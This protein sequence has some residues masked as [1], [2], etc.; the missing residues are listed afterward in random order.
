MSNILFVLFLFLGNS[1][2]NLKYRELPRFW[3]NTGFCPIGNVSQVLLSQDEEINI[4]LIGS[5]PNNGIKRVRIHWLLDLVEFSHYREHEIPVFDFEKLDK[6]MDSL[7]D[8]GLRVGFEL[9]GNPSGIFKNNSMWKMW[10]ELVFQIGKRYIDRYGPFKIR[11]WRFESWNEPDLTTYNKLNFTLPDYMK[12]LDSLKFG[13]SAAS[14]NPYS[15]T[16]VSLSGPAGL[17]KNIKHH[18]LCW[19]ILEECNKNVTK[20]PFDILTFHRKGESGGAS[21]IY[22]GGK[23]LLKEIFGKFP[24]LRALKISNNEADPV[25]GWSTPRDFQGDVRYAVKLVNTVLLHWKA[26]LMDDEFKNLESISHDNA[27]LSYHPF[28]FNQRTLFARFQMN[29]SQPIYSEFIV[30]PVYVA[31]GL[32]GNLG[33]YAGDLEEQKILDNKIKILKTVGALNTKLPNFLAWLIVA[34]KNTEQKYSFNVLVENPSNATFALLIE[35]VEPETTDPA[36]IWNRYDRPSYPERKFLELMRMYEGPKIAQHTLINENLM[37]ISCE[38]RSPAIALI[39]LCSDRI[40]PP[41]KVFDLRF[42]FVHNMEILLT[43]KEGFLRERC[44]KTYEIFQKDSNENWTMISRNLEIPFLYFFYYP[45]KGDVRGEYK[46]RGVDMFGRSGEF[47]DVIKV[48]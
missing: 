43:W 36:W 25:S 20:C 3:T 6:L 47:S 18:L 39:R 19:G 40:E 16:H 11:D 26:K 1:T 48:K 21:Q 9:M 4:R 37:K 30:K 31:L 44:V 5:L 17:F 28:E 27:F 7:D 23:Q 38:L 14:R 33:S 34:T 45:V 46:V 12:Y 32:L 13:L 42:T 2:S 41:P 10:D 24:N 22:F 8:S 15:S 29:K 35:T